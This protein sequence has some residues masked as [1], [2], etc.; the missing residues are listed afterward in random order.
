[1]RRTFRDRGLQE[2]FTADGFAVTELLAAEEVETLLALFERLD[3]PVR[4]GFF[5]TVE[6]DELEYKRAMATAVRDV[7]GDR[8]LVL[9]D[10]HRLVGGYFVVKWPGPDSAK[11]P[12]LDWSL[13]D[14]ARFR[15][16]SVWVPLVDV[17]EGNGHLCL[18]RGSHHLVGSTQRGSPDF[19][20]RLEV[21][22]VARSFNA[23]A[24]VGLTLPAGHAVVYNHQTIHCSPANLDERPRPAVNIAAIPSEAPL[25]HFRERRDGHLDRMAVD[26][27]FFDDWK[28]RGDPPV[29]QRIDVVPRI[30]TLRRHP[31]ASEGLRRPRRW[32][33]ARR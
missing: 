8:V 7:L 33:W 6:T 10:D 11:G 25:L 30:D 13:V 20:T 12:H 9:L 17:D 26:D 5:A 19:P 2:A 28:W 14:E 15:S 22:D 23:E 4:R 3:H 18:L 1:M 27:D 31:G 24:M 32:A 29:A 21:E 16:V